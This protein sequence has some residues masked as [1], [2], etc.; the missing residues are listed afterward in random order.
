MA[1][2]EWTRRANIARVTHQADGLH[3]R[4]G[5]RLSG[6]ILVLVLDQRRWRGE[7]E[8][9]ADLFLSR[10]FRSTCDRT[11]ARNGE[12]R[13]CW[14]WDTRLDRTAPNIEPGIPLGSGDIESFNIEERMILPEIPG[15]RQTLPIFGAPWRRRNGDYFLEICLLSQSSSSPSSWRSIRSSTLES[16]MTP[17]PFLYTPM[18]LRTPAK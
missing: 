16:S 12:R 4:H 9:L 7:I 10:G 13:P 17:R 2:A 11:A 6:R 1:G 3:W 18:T 14:G 5:G 15:E 8:W